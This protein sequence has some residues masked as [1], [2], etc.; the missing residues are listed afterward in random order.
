M[1]RPVTV[2]LVLLSTL[3]TLSVVFAYEKDGYFRGNWPGWN[4]WHGWRRCPRSE[5]FRECESSSCGEQKCWQ[6]WRQDG[7]KPCTTDCVSRCFCR[8]GL[9]RD[10]WG[11]C[12]PDW[13]CPRIQ[14]FWR[15]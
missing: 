3:A 7:Q 9:Y 11:R 4:T 12:V 15:Y 6:L 5:V 13:L 8:A 2:L 10:P 1:C 14:Y